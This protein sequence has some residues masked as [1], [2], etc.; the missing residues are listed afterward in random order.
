[1]GA[2]QDSEKGAS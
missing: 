2:R 1:M